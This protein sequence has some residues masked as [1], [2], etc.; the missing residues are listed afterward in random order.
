MKIKKNHLDFFSKYSY[1]ILLSLFTSFLIFVDIDYLN[2]DGAMY[3]KQAFFFE[4]DQKFEANSLYNWPFYSYFIL[5]IKKISGLPLLY[6]AKLLNF[7]LLILLFKTILDISKK[8]IK[9]Y[10]YPSIFITTISSVFLFDNYINM[11][12]RDIGY[13]AFFFLGFNSYLN[14]LTHKKIKYFFITI[15]FIIFCSLFRIEGIVFLFVIFIYELYKSIIL[16]KIS[17]H[18]FFYIFIF[19]ILS[20]LFLS[21]YFNNFGQILYLR[22]EENLNKIFF[23]FS[24]NNSE[25]YI[26][27]DNYYL[28]KLLQDYYFGFFIIFYI[29]IALF[30]WIGGYGLFHI[31][32]IFSYIKNK[33]IIKFNKIFIFSFSISI[34]LVL[35]NFITTDVITTRYLVLSFL[36]I[37]FYAARYISYMF[38]D[39]GISNFYKSFLYILF[40]FNLLLIFTDKEKINLQKEVALWVSNNNIKLDDI[41]IEDDRINYYLNN[42]SSLSFEYTYLISNS[43]KK[44]II[45]SSDIDHQTITTY[46]LLRSIP[47]SKPKY[48]IYI[49]NEK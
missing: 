2:K 36:I 20:V 33:L 6:A 16:K 19:V 4:N 1:L 43:Q 49:I 8:V 23:V 38:F 28:N 26:S 5:W 37:N 12:I 41:Y 44:Y 29:Y 39:N 32:L 25:F 9:K 13:W 17:K 46:N 14:Y 21:L 48:N 27:S 15:L 11:V 45:L 3:I 34:F 22:I 30:K 7:I 35:V 18:Y 10:A 42:F 24:K 31:L 40:I 47:I